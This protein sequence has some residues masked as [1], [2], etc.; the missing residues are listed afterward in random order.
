VLQEPLDLQDQ[1]DRTLAASL[2]RRL[3]HY[4]D[5]D[6]Q[7]A[8]PARVLR[9]PGTQNFKYD[10]P[11]HVVVERLEPE[12][13]YNISEFEDLL[14]PEPAEANRTPFVAPEK[15]CDG[16]RNSTL[17]KTGRMLK[18]KGLSRAA[19]RAALLAENASKC[20]PPLPDEEVERIVE[21]A[22]SQ[23]D[24]PAF[25]QNGKPTPHSEPEPRASEP[26]EP[27]PIAS[28]TVLGA[29]PNRRAIAE[30]PVPCARPRLT[31]SRSA[32]ESR[33]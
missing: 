19:I 8:E 22:W 14:P 1:A 26:I 3:A 33:R 21:S 24:R 23:A 17:Y 12:R 31:S 5:A 25:M 15:I 13:R 2:L 9:L 10:P 28:E 16:A 32:D 29:R 20:A 27:D 7:A 11:R 18:A 6:L 4:L 30:R